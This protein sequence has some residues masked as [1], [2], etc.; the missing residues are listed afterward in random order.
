MLGAK[1]GAP[2]GSSGT[3][4]QA[5]SPLIHPCDNIL[6][7]LIL[8]KDNFQPLNRKALFSSSGKDVPIGPAHLEKFN[9]RAQV[10][11]GHAIAVSRSC[12]TPGEF[13]SKRPNSGAAA[14]PVRPRSWRARRPAPP[15][16]S[17]SCRTGVRQF[18]TAHHR[19]PVRTFWGCRGEDTCATRF[20]VDLREPQTGARLFGKELKGGMRFAF[21]PYGLWF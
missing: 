13:F 19:H 12:K 6:K 8:S 9:P 3:G 5:M 20:V 11:L 14:V 18:L 17:G 2:R 1:L 10:V 21:P 16:F 15:K 7:N 4:N